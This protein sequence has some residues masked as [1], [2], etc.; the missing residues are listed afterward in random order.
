MGRGVEHWRQGDC[1]L[2]N[3]T[4][5][6]NPDEAEA[7]EFRETTGKVTKVNESF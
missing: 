2:L 4:G 1:K 7:T 5:G 3:E 6:V